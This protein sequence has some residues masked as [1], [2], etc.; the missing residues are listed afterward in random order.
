MN[1]HAGDLRGRQR[2]LCFMPTNARKFPRVDL[3]FIAEYVSGRRRFRHRVTNV[4]GGGLFIHSPL[5]LRPGAE[6]NLSFRPTRRSPVIHARGKVRYTFPGVGYGVEFVRIS[7][8][9]RNVMLRLVHRRTIGRRK[10]P[11]V[12][13]VAQIEHGRSQPL[14]WVKDISPGGLFIETRRLPAPGSQV[15]VRFN[16][17]T[18][19]A[20]IQARC[21]VTYHLP[22]TGMGVQFVEISEEDLQ[23][24]R[25][26]IEKHFPP[27]RSKQKKRKPK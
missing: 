11:R 1:C 16:L 9:A 26:Y 5:V 4:S 12:P 25:A 18:H 3:G 15:L 17:P 13:L 27:V 20:V 7:R 24:I 21:V 6:L 2:D 23:I 19:N 14:G 10:Q 22:A 8:E